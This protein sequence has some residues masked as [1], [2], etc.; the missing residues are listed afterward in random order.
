MHDDGKERDDKEACGRITD[1][2][3]NVLQ[4]SV[5]APMILDLVG[6][7]AVH[8]GCGVRC[9]GRRRE[10]GQAMVA[11]GALHFFK[12]SAPNSASLLP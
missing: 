8:P 5:V 12:R 6:D 3:F 2:A 4:L 10:T 11:Y 9:L 7:N 1:P